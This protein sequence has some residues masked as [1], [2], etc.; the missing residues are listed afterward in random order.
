MHK[1]QTLPPYFSNI[2]KR[3]VKM[4]KNYFTDTGVLAHLLGIQTQNE[5]DKSEHKGM[6]I[7]TFVFM[8]LSKHIAYSEHQAKLSH[9]RTTDQKE[10]DFII[11]YKNKIIAIE[12][13]ANYGVRQD[14]FKH[15]IGLA[16][17]EPKLAMGIVFYM[18]DKVLPFGD[19]L[20]ALPLGFFF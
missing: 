7:E 3:F 2:S 19:K 10:I 5:F 13:K 17:K 16:E 15:I 20:L 12:V 8:E 11:E 14:D 1:I 9:F 6:L 18:G 4:P